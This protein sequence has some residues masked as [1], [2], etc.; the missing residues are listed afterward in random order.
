MKSRLMNATAL[1]AALA[2]VFAAGATAQSSGSGVAGA[3]VGTVNIDAGAAEDDFTFYGANGAFVGGDPGTMRFQVD[4]GYQN[5]DSDPSIDGWNANGH[6]LFGSE[7][8]TFGG[9]VTFADTDDESS[10]GGGGEFRLNSANTTFGGE[11]GYLDGD[12]DSKII[13]GAGHIDLFSSENLRFGGAA[14]YGN[15]DLGPAD[16]NFFGLTGEVELQL[17]DSPFSVVGGVD[18]LSVDDADVDAL[19]FR[20]G[21]NVAFGT[22][23]L[24]QR[25]QE[26]ASMRGA[27]YLTGGF[28]N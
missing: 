5:I 17:P 26:G 8:T 15:V 19:G 4:A 10:W 12:E 28:S 24:Q 22:R 1:G 14:S 9:F 2:I 6:L 25:Y 7:M 27:R 16:T 20:I 11:L 3:Y 13:A 23:S 18:W 21:F